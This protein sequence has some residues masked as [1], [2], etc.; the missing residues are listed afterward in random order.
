MAYYLSGGYVTKAMINGKIINYDLCTEESK[1]TPQIGFEFIGRGTIYSAGG[2]LQAGNQLHSFF[3]KSE[4][5]DV[6][7]KKY[8]LKI[9]YPVSEKDFKLANDLRTDRLDKT[10]C[11]KSG[12]ILKFNN[13]DSYF[14]SAFP[15]SWLTEIK[16]P[17][18]FDEWFKKWFSHYYPN[19]NINDQLELKVNL[20]NSWNAALENQK[21]GVVDEHTDEKACED[22]L[23]SNKLKGFTI[24][25][26]N[27]YHFDLDD[28]WKAA[29]KYARGIS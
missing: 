19:G 29:L 28:F 2:V 8:Q 10:E 27:G 6:M 17:L 23:D 13:R 11:I 9:I 16:V 18:S 12:N 15:K 25:C 5:E 3:I 21:L 24:V 20:C 1:Y 7:T 4:E 26:E 14:L 22:W